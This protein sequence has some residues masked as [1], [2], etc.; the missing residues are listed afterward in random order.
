MHKYFERKMYKYFLLA[1]A[2]IFL[3][4]VYFI[5]LS[6]FKLS[7]SLKYENIKE[8]ILI[9]VNININL[10]LLIESLKIIWKFE[11]QEGYTRNIDY[12]EMIRRF[13][14][15]MFNRNPFKSIYAPIH[16]S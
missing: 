9:S 8:Y 13:G 3:L 7:N 11:R 16:F 1:V 5:H 6:D 14:R 2:K 12:I 10:S 15:K 4:Q